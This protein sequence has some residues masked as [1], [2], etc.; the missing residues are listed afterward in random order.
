MNVVARCKWWSHLLRTQVAGHGSLSVCCKVSSV[1]VTLSSSVRTPLPPF[2]GR[3]VTLPEGW[4]LGVGATRK[5]GPALSLSSPS[6]LDLLALLRDSLSSEHQQFRYH[7]LSVPGLPGTECSLESSR[8]PLIKHPTPDRSWL[9][10]NKPL[11]VSLRW[12]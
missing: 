6:S 12:N 3:S 10:A 7:T 5:P 11:S 8:S 9:S 4:G 2:L 1:A